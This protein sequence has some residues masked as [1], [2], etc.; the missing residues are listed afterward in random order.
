MVIKIT[1]M[2]LNFRKKD[3]TKNWW[4]NLNTQ[5]DSQNISPIELGCRGYIG[6]ILRRWLV[7]ELK[8]NPKVFTSSNRVRQD[9]GSG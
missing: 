9:I 3:Y 2:L 7:S 1:L 6:D 8:P 5:G 4:R